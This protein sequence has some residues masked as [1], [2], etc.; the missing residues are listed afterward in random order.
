MSATPNDS[1]LHIFCNFLLRSV[2]NYDVF[3]EKVRLGVRP[4]E[5]KNLCLLVAFHPEDVNARGKIGWVTG[6]LDKIN[7]IHKYENK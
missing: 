3:V 7:N 1:D 2:E 4:E 5:K 6:P